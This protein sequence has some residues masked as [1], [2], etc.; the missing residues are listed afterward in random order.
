MNVSH[1]PRHPNMTSSWSCVPFQVHLTAWRMSMRHVEE[2]HCRKPST[3]CTDPVW[4]RT[5]QCDRLERAY[6]NQTSFVYYHRR[7]LVCRV[8]RLQFIWGVNLKTSFI[9]KL[10]RFHHSQ[11]PQC[12]S[13]MW[14]YWSYVTLTRVVVYRGLLLR[15]TPVLSIQTAAAPKQEISAGRRVL[16]TNER[17]VM[18]SLYLHSMVISRVCNNN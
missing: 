2:V 3:R 11:C 12:W 13:N 8:A 1:S 17:R 16:G 5:M 6:Y 4:M 9:R 18:G 7:V 14:L 10:A 15:R